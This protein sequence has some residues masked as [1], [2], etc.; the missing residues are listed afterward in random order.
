MRIAADGNPRASSL[1]RV[2]PGR[3]LFRSWRR[4]SLARLGGRFAAQRPVVVLQPLA[5]PLQ[6]LLD[7]PDEVGDGMEHLRPAELQYE[8]PG[9]LRRCD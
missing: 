1:R 9:V 5:I 3:D 8:G 6:P 7:P 2:F 4:D